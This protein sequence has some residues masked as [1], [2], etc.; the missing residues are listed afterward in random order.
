MWCLE[1]RHRRCIEVVH[2]SSEKDSIE[3][4]F[5]EENQIDES[6]IWHKEEYDI[7]PQIDDDDGG[8]GEE[9]IC[10]LEIEPEG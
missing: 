10:W 7:Q 3:V 6:E 5:N 9:V 4:E 2:A 1:P 8:E